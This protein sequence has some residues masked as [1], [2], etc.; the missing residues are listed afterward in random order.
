MYILEYTWFINVY[1]SIQI[2]ITAFRQDKSRHPSLEPVESL[3][4]S[5]VWYIH[6]I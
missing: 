1:A 2:Y 4:L 5:Y 6:V 3:D